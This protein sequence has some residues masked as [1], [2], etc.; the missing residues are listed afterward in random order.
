MNDGKYVFTQVTQLVPRQIFQRLVKKYNGDYR[1]REFN[2]TNQLKYML[3][4]QLLPCDSL[5]DICL[6]LSKH[7]KILYGLGRTSLLFPEPMRV[8]TTA[9]L[10]A[11]GRH[12]SR[13]LG[14]CTPNKG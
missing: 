5:R 11:L 2:C 3:F 8:G 1:V 9:S 7:E 10:K 14:Q 4:G 13:L 12:S 6:C